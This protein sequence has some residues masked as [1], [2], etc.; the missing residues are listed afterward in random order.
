MLS[1]NKNLNSSRYMRLMGLAGIDVLLTVPLSAYLSIYLTVVLGVSPWLGWADTHYDFHVIQQ[2]PA[3]EWRSIP[4]VYI[5]MEL[6]RW[7]PILCAAVFF[8]FFGFAQE[9][10]KNYRMA[11][12]SVAKRVGYTSSGGM[13]SAGISSSFGSK[14]PMSF[15][16][17]AT[18]PI[19]VN[20]KTTMKRD[21]Y[22]SFSTNLTIGDVGG[23]LDDIKASPY[24]PT[25]SMESGSSCSFGEKDSSVAQPPRALNPESPPHYELEHESAR[26]DS[27]TINLA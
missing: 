22:A 5:A 6:T 9:A 4:N 17:Q 16:G 18:L 2:Y 8:A 19:F 20:Q 14:Q 10:R 13:S 11:L 26:P 27:Q 15:N 1:G 3:F 24:S 21:S 25:D 23:T 12:N 7:S